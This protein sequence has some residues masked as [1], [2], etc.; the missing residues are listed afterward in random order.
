MGFAADMRCSLVA[1]WDFP[2]AAQSRRTHILIYGARTRVRL[3][4]TSP[5]AESTA[6]VRGLAREGST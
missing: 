3:L 6:G 4:V 2:P 1:A 5:R